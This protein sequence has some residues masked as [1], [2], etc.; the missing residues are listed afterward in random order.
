M[1]RTAAATGRCPGSRR[2]RRTR[3]AHAQRRENDR[4][5]VAITSSGATSA[6]SSTTEHESTIDSAIGTSS[7]RVARGGLRRSYSTAVGPPTRRPAHRPRW[8]R[9]AGRGSRRRPASSTGR[10]RGRRRAGRPAALARGCGATAA[11]PSTRAAARPLHAR[12]GRARRCRSAPSAP[13]GTPRR[14][15]PGPRSTRPRRGT[16]CSASGRR[17]VRGCPAPA[18]SSSDGR[19]DPDAPRA[20]GD[21]LADPPP[22]AVRL[23]GALVAEV[24]DE[25]PER[26]RPTMTS[27]AG[28]KVSIDGHRDRDPERADRAQPGGAVDL[29]ERQAQQRDA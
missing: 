11:T 18:T 17:E 23:V 25:R 5:T 1:K 9:R 15:A 3:R 24:R 21:P 28:R 10:A 22:R 19:G 8:P 4:T 7:A 27:S 20:R 6:R 29:R 2:S 26:R 12:R 13:P 14:A 16:R